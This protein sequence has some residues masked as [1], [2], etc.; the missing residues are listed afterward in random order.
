MP[1]LS[2]IAD[3]SMGRAVKHVSMR[4]GVIA[5][6]NHNDLVLDENHV[7]DLAYSLRAITAQL[8]N[9]KSQ[10]RQIPRQWAAK[11]ETRYAKLDV[12]QQ[13]TPQEKAAMEA[14]E[15][16][17]DDAEEPVDFEAAAT[18]ALAHKSPTAKIDALCYTELIICLNTI[19]NY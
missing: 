4:E 13:E 1:C 16:G 8:M 10:S 5:W 18:A 12:Q 19:I 15:D 14:I 9:M 3:A 6:S 2:C 17:D 7:D 11:F